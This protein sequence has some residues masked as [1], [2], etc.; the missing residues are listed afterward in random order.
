MKRYLL[1]IVALIGIY[2]ISLTPAFATTYYGP[3]FSTPVA[4]P[5]GSPI[6]IVLSTASGSTIVPLPQGSNQPC[7]GTCSYPQQAWTT[8]SACFVSV[9]EVTVT[10]PNG[11]EFMLGSSITSGLYWPA[12]FGGSGSGT[13]V[14]PQAPA[15]NFTVGDTFT[16]PFG[17]GAE[18]YMFSSVL[19]SPYN[20]N[21]EGPY[22][23][24][25][26]V[27]APGN[28]NG[29]TKGA[30][31]DQTNINPTTT[32]GTY[33]VDIEG[34]VACP[35]GESGFKDILFFDSGI[36][37]TTPE[38]GVGMAAATVVGLVG[39]LVLRKKMPI[40]LNRTSKM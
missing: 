34:V 17:T 6:D 5:P 19:G 14:P 39:L 29:Y 20:T 23:W 7:S 40:S 21:P 38:F 8:P 37:V 35:G 27:V 32:Q 31:L 3:S 1:A 26:A 18:G 4:V 15:L 10:D 25:I 2:W 33:T 9:H 28:P 36:I 22:Y 13:S 12:A 24:W 30:R 16:L 11:N